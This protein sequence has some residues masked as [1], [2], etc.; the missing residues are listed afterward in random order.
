MLTQKKATVTLEVFLKRMHSLL[1][2]NIE[3]FPEYEAGQ[4]A[5]ITCH[6]TALDNQK[7]IL[8]MNDMVIETMRQA[9]WE[10]IG[11][12]FV[13]NGIEYAFDRE[14]EKA[15]SSQEEIDSICSKIAASS[16]R[17]TYGLYSNVMMIDGGDEEEILVVDRGPGGN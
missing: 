5:I 2:G 12:D 3:D 11:H 15:D 17:T 9:G 8:E 13:L 6:V 4:I 16:G 1:D 7:T 14:E 10:F